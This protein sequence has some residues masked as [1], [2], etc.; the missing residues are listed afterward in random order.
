MEHNSAEQEKNVSFTD[1]GQKHI[2]VHIYRLC[3]HILYVCVHVFDTENTKE[4]L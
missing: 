4:Q 3:V 1:L 2:C